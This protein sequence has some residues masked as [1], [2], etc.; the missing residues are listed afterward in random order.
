M[1]FQL[2]FEGVQWQTSRAGLQWQNVPRGRPRE[3]EA[4]LSDWCQH[5]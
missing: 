3:S 1:S 4:P 5:A 2:L